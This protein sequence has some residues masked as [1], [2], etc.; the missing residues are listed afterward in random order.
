VLLMEQNTRIKI[1]DFGISKAD[2]SHSTTTPKG[3]FYYLPPES[4]GGE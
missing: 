1:C 4:L 2:D 3:T